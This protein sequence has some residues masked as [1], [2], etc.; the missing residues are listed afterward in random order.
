MLFVVY[1]QF[2]LI[3]RR[4]ASGTLRHV[5]LVEIYRQLH[6]VDTEHEDQIPAIS[7][8]KAK[9]SDFVFFTSYF[10]NTSTIESMDLCSIYMI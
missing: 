6:V 4:A 3:F 2:L 8:F 1:V 7:A 9:V 10:T 5:G